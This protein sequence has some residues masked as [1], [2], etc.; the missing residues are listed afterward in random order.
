MKHT[1]LD[2][3]TCLKPL[4]LDDVAAFYGV[5]Q[6]NRSHLDEWLRWSGRIQTPADAKA[7]IQRFELKQEQNDGF[8]LGIW[9]DETLMGGVICHFIN[10]ESARSEVG[11][12]LSANAV[13]HGLASRATRTVIDYLF[14]VMQLHRVKIVCGVDNHRSRAIPERLGFQLE[15][16]KR[17]SE[18]VSTRFVDHALYAILSY[19]WKKL[20]TE[21]QV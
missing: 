6:Q 2:E 10:H 9:Q 16:I 12:W 11:Y 14:S 5:L 13:G 7:F 19:E 18:W 1:V 15:G 17:E 21:M 3:R 4:T 20:T 8:H